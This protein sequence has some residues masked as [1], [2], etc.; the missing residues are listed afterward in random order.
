[1]KKYSCNLIKLIFSDKEQYIE[2]QNQTLNKNLSNTN[3]GKY[4]KYGR[5]NS[6]ENYTSYGKRKS[7]D[8]EYDEYDCQ[9]EGEPPNK[10][11][12]ESK[13][14]TIVSWCNDLDRLYISIQKYILSSPIL[15]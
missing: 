8:N 1:M 2:T 3:D 11:S 10:V 13:C 7:T 12:S 4:E 5:T 14:Q 9:H 15:S 6:N